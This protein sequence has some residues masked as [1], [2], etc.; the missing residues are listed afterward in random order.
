MIYHIKMSH[1][2]ASRIWNQDLI[3]NHW[4]SPLG[5]IVAKYSWVLLWNLNLIDAHKTV[6]ISLKRWFNTEIY[7]HGSPE[8][9]Y[10]AVQLFLISF[11]VLMN[12]Y[13][14]ILPSY[15]FM[16]LNHGSVPVCKKMIK[17]N[18]L[19]KSSFLDISI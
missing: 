11:T 16:N 18:R 19:Y 6:W 12:S 10:S 15:Y 14:L 2:Q 5:K 17:Y 8:Q 4:G 1:F 9:S 13:L 7:L 3:S